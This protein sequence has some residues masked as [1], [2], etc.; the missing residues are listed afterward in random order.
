MNWLLQRF[1]A[2]LITGIGI[3][4]GGD[5]YEAVKAKVKERR[6]G[7][8]DDEAAAGAVATD[9]AEAPDDPAAGAMIVEEVVP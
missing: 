7:A 8:I 9:D 3:K 2:A 1:A 4:M 5:L 6:Q